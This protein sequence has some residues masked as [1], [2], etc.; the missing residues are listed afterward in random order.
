[1]YLF[2]IFNLAKYALLVPLVFKCRLGKPIII[3][4]LS[5]YCLY[6]AVYVLAVMGML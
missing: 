3:I 2:T 5:Y 4:A 6:Q 1:M